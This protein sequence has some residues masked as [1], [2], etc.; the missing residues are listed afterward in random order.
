MKKT[1]IVDHVFNGQCLLSG[2]LLLDFKFLSVK[3]L[4]SSKL[5]VTADKQRFTCP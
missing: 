3:E 5:H 4:S 1:S 2:Q